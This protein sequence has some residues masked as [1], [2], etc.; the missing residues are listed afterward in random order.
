VVSLPTLACCSLIR[1]SALVLFQEGK[2]KKRV[3]LSLLQHSLLPALESLVS[4]QPDVRA[5]AAV[6]PPEPLQQADGQRRV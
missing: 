2:R 1:L 5:L 6:G 4:Q 3:F